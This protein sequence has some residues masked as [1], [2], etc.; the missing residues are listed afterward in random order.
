MN[1]AS[2]KEIAKHRAELDA[3]LSK[4]MAEHSEQCGCGWT[5]DTF[6]VVA[7]AVEVALERCHVPMKAV[8]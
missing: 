7:C 1:S 8:A 5:A 4:V 3:F 6:D 2:G